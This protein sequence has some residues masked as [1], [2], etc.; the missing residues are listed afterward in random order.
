[1]VSGVL[2][3]IE[4]AVKMVRRSLLVMNTYLAMI[5]KALSDSV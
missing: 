5:L 4:G 2:V 1:M 3:G